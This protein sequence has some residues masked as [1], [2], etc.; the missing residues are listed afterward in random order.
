MDE[1]KIDKDFTQTSDLDNKQKKFRLAKEFNELLCLLDS[2]L[3]TNNIDPRCPACLDCK[4]CKELAITCSTNVEAT[5]H[6]EESILK[7][8]IKFDPIQGNFCVPLP[9]KDNPDIALGEY[10]EQAKSFYRRV[11]NKLSKSP[12]DKKAIIKSFNRQIELGFIQKLSDMPEELQ[13]AI[14]SKK[15]YVIPWNYLEFIPYND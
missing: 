8:C 2:I 4:Q 13:R 12:E 6:R 10:A 3:Q 5:M 11:V 7:E 1:E 14:N 9:L 15:K